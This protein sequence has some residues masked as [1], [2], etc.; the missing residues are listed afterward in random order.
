MSSPYSGGTATTLTN[1]TGY[2]SIDALLGDAKWGAGVGSGATVTY[3][4]PWAG[5]ANAVYGGPGSESYSN[6][7]E[8]G[9]T[10][11]YGLNAVEQAAAAAALQ[12][13][14]NVANITF[15]NTTETSTSVGDIRFA[16]TSAKETVSDGTDAWGWAYYPSSRY[17]SGGDVWLSATN[18]DTDWSVGSF[19]YESLMHEAGHALGLK[20]PF[21]DG[22]TDAAHATTQYSIMAY[23][24]A[25]NNVFG[26]ITTVGNKQYWEG[27]YVQP[28]TPMLNDIA[29]IQYLYG[30]NM[31]YHT[32][33]DTYTFDPSTPFLRTIW[34]AGGND[35]IS[36][37]NFSTD[38]VIDLREGAY[39]SIVIPSASTDGFTWDGPAPT[40]LYDGTDNLAIAY[41]AVIENAV[42]GSGDDTLI[43]N[44]GAN[45]LQGNDGV[46][47]LD[48]G[49]GIDTAVYTGNFSEY[50]F[51]ILK[52]S[53]YSGYTVTSR[54]VVTQ[55]DGLINIE[56]LAFKDG[57]MS[58]NLNSLAD[59]PLQAQ[60][61]AL[62]QK[63]YV[64]Y[65]GRPADAAG[66]ASMVAQFAAAKV[67]T[68]TG[69]F[70]SAYATNATVKALVDSF[71]N[72]NES[73]KLYSGS[74]DDFVTSIYQHLLGRAPLQAGLDFWSDSIDGGGLARGLAAL[75]IMSGAEGNTTAQG[76][77]DAGL[78]A[79][80]V[81]VAANFTALLDQPSE[82][83]GYAGATAAASARAM[84]DAVRQDTSITA[85]E[86]TVFSTVNKLA[87]GAQA[88]PVEVALVGVAGHEALA[89]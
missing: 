62:A 4:F 8:P 66:L 15:T 38:C 53:N 42:G 37:A 82:V 46:N 32:G 56:R 17:S 41:G 31:S 84:L 39:S 63:F 7:N 19:N 77:I 30:A 71:G 3:S 65:F 87:G 55:G 48:G 74:T 43:G 59:D 10:Q 64:A 34:D 22:V 89:A 50:E 33:A 35:T 6:L 73:A 69:G 11:H 5:G 45:R 86:S 20:H 57:T 9:A 60:Y 2:V 81:T 70:V 13:W 61:V 18:T 49:D 40:G 67:P 68:T 72:S 1:L 36:V 44:A 29:A 80:R 83:A 24:N 28:D 23:D 47:V 79:N 52:G 21:E 12:S 16:Y 76:L 54:N 88:H 26:R 85:Y 14:A 25:P 78:I 58:L 51:S 27:S 75:G